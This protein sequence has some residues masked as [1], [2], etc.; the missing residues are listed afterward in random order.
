VRVQA[1]KA[2]T[3]EPS[4]PAPEGPEAAEGAERLGGGRVDPAFV[5]EA[6]SVVRGLGHLRVVS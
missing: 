6:A 5:G 4:V 2:L 3:V 1:G